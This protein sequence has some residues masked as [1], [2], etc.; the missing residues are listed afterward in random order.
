MWGDGFG[1]VGL[2]VLPLPFFLEG[3][4]LEKEEFVEGEARAGLV[5]NFGVLG[6]M[7]GFYCLV[8]R[9]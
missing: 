4:E 8:I 9:H 7:D 5:E 2:N 3:A 1:F 6:E